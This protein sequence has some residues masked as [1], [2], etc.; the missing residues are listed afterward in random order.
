MS[1]ERNRASTLSAARSA[2]GALVL[3]PEPTRVGTPE[4]MP[5][6]HLARALL[7]GGTV[8]AQY[9]D[10]WLDARVQVSETRADYWDCLGGYLC[11]Y[12]RGSVPAEPIGLEQDPWAAG[13]KRRTDSTVHSRTNPWSSA[14]DARLMALVW[15][16]I[17]WARA[18]SRALAALR[19]TAERPFAPHVARRSMR[20]RF[21]AE[22]CLAAFLECAC[23]DRG[24]VA[25]TLDPSLGI[26][27]G[28]LAEIRA[29]LALH[30]AGVRVVRW[31]QP[32][33]CADP[34]HAPAAA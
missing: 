2:P 22:G 11:S 33:W 16:A 17:D 27:R 7:R 10:G 3:N 26:A 18:A 5:V 6:G 29:L 25:T 20:E 31:E 32:R 23:Y 8:T 15:E 28:N 34:E 4:Y 30:G 9:R 24:F 12:E 13:R 19:C 14:R 21:D 1:V